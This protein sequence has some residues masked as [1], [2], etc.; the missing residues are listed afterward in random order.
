MPEDYSPDLPSDSCVYDSDSCVY[1]SDSCV[2]DYVKCTNP[3]GWTQT[4]KANGGNLIFKTSD[5][6]FS[7]VKVKFGKEWTWDS[8]LKQHEGNSW[9]KSTKEEYLSQF[10]I[11]QKDEQIHSLVES[12]SSISS[13]HN[14]K[15]FIEPVHSVNLKLRTKNKSI[16]F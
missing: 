7:L 5:F 8:V 10:V 2:Y 9:V 11:T 13:V 6:D 16:K 12:V 3:S 1:D 15:T 4:V 14:H